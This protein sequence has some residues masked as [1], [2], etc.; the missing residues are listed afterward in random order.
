[1]APKQQHQKTFKKTL[2]SSEPPPTSEAPVLTRFRQVGH[3]ALDLRRI[4]GLQP[5]QRAAEVREVQVLGGPN[6]GKVE[7]F[8]THRF[9]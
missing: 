4:C 5:G 7:G 2:R 8:R 3:V 6:G 9:S 1:M